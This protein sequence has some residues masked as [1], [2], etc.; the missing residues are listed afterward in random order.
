MKS[1]WYDNYYEE[2]KEI[3]EAKSHH[4]AKLII[5]GRL[6]VAAEWQEITNDEYHKLLDYLSLSDRQMKVLKS[7]PSYEY[8]E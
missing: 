8:Q 4:D 3:I 1:K 5:Y 6:S 7:I 2:I